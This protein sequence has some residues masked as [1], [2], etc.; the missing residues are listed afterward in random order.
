MKF[1]Y[2]GNTVDYY[3]RSLAETAMV[4]VKKYYRILSLRNYIIQISETYGMIKALNKLIRL[5]MLNM[6]VII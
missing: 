3:K 5:G 1:S 4:R 2:L 6:K